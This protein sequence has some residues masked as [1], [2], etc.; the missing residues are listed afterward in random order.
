ME[1]KEDDTVA[2]AKYTPISGGLV[3]NQ[4]RPSG[5]A[6]NMTLGSIKTTSEF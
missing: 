1:K 2:A 4:R 3:S 6:R 5:M